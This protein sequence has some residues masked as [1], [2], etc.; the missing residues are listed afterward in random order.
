VFP[1]GCDA[2]Y[3]EDHP[4]HLNVCICLALSKV[5]ARCAVKAEW[6]IRSMPA[7]ALITAENVIG[8]LLAIAEEEHAALIKSQT[9]ARTG[10]HKPLLPPPTLPF[11]PR[12][13]CPCS[14]GAAR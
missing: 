7:I 11:T 8:R 9:T 6:G 14:P 12:H 5:P 4:A 1:L 10:A 13:S 3:E 2:P